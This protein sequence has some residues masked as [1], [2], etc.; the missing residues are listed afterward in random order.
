[1]ILFVAEPE[2]RRL[3]NPITAPWRA[4]AAWAATLAFV[5]VALTSFWRKPLR[6]PY[7]PWRLMHGVLATAGIALPWPT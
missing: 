6:I 4:Q 1:V 5:L 2:T 7:E 3:L